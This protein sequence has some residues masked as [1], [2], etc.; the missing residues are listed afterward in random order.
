GATL[1]RAICMCLWESRA[2][3]SEGN[4]CR[5]S[6]GFTLSKLLRC[7]GSAKA[8]LACAP[9]TYLSSRVIT[10][11]VFLTGVVTWPRFRCDRSS[12]PIHRGSR[13][14]RVLIRANGVLQYLRLHIAVRRSRFRGDLRRFLRRPIW[15]FENAPQHPRQ[16][17]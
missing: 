17:R 14:E 7:A 13:R 6:S 2:E 12:R 15:P 8:R 16:I 9:P 5:L 10:A 4:C 11:L 1:A 3:I